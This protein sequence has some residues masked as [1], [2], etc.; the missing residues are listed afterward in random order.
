MKYLLLGDTYQTLFVEDDQRIYSL[1]YDK[2]EDN[3]VY[4]G[5]TLLD[6][7]IGFDPSEDEDSI[8]HYGNSGC[9]KPII[10]IT[11][12]EAEQFISRPIDDSLLNELLEAMR[13]PY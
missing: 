2:K 13:N 11:H 3:W 12:E 5:T 7:R 8:Y 6:N 10:E 4:G 1:R 9:M